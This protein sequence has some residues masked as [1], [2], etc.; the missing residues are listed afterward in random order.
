MYISISTLRSNLNENLSKVL[1]LLMNDTVSFLGYYVVRT[2][3]VRARVYV[4]LG[5]FL[6]VLTI[7]FRSRLAPV[8]I[9]RLRS[10]EKD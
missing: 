2:Y 4:R 3:S 7:T 9:I 6:T 5:I 1:F 10:E 8:E